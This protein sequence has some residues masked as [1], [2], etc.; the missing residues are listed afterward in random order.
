MGKNRY[1]FPDISNKKEKKDVEK[2]VL[3]VEVKKGLVDMSD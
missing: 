2:P 1:T 3:F